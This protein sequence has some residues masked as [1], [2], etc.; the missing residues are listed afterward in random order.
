M[1]KKPAFL[2]DDLPHGQAAG[3]APVTNNKLGGPAGAEPAKI[4][5]EERNS[6]SPHQQS[7]TS[8]PLS[9]PA[10]L[11]EKAFHGLAGDFVR[12]VEPHTESDP[13]ALLV[14]FLVF[15]GNA[16]GRASYFPVEA[17][18]HFSN[19]FAVILGETSK[20]RKGT[21]AQHVRRLFERAE[22]IWTQDRIV[23]G[24]SSGEGLISEIRDPTEEEGGSADKRLMVIESEFASIL[25]Q[26]E[27]TGNTLSV[28]LRNAWDGT[29]LRSLT[30]TSP[31]KASAP[32]VSV[33]GHCTIEELRRYLTLTET[34]NGFGNRILWTCARRSKLLPD[35]GNLHSEAMN[36][37]GVALADALAFARSGREMKRD[38]DARAL[39]HASY[40]KLSEGRPG[41]AGALTARSEAHVVRLAMIY[42]LL[43]RSEVIGEKHLLAALELWRYCEQSVFTIFGTATGDP[44][45]DKI[46]HHLRANP[47]GM[48][49]TDI[50]GLLGRHQDAARIDQALG[51]LVQHDHARCERVTTNGRS[52]EVWFASAK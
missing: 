41:L 11:G 13:A 23:S 16:A 2:R 1:K 37:I 30:K 18:H 42:S 39:W 36:D 29:T 44:V 12:K 20:A 7:L 28:I 15:F 32:H 4:P 25:K 19:E 3:Q 26:T 40:A 49:R 34:A 17:T 38:N 51:V 47:A 5:N 24:L 31:L 33:I 35:G 46:L 27:R 10:P 22:P 48:P 45:A 14:Q 21:S 9:W 52:A 8:P 43:D 6:T 50:S